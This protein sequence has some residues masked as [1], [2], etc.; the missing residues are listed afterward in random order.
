MEELLIGIQDRQPRHTE[1]PG[2]RA[3]RWKTLT[4][5]EPA[6]Q[7]RGADTLVDLP[8]AGRGARSIEW[9]VQR[10]RVTR[11]KRR[12]SGYVVTSGNGHC[13]SP[14]VRTRCGMWRAASSVSA[15]VHHAE[16]PW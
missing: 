14:H 13:T 12:E 10:H 1:F 3:R 7:N 9:N 11:G 6:F 8:V 16:G 2:Q 5:I 15:L 4:V